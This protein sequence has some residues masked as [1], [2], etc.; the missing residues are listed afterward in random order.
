MMNARFEFGENFVE[1]TNFRH[2]YEEFVNPYNTLFDLN[3]KSGNFTGL[4]E[5]HKRAQ[6]NA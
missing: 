5:F 3:V 2:F 6:R 1:I 4:A